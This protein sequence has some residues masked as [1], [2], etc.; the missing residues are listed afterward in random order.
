MTEKEKMLRGELYDAED[1][2][3]KA[4]RAIAEDALRRFGA[5]G[6]ASVLHG[7]LGGVGG[8]STVRSPFYCE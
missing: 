6:D 7:L 2:V 4:E 3:L 5:T 8:G 1:A